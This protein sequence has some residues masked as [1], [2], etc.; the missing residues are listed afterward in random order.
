[1]S[2]I[3]CTYLSFGDVV[4]PIGAAAHHVDEGRFRIVSISRVCTFFSVVSTVTV[5]PAVLRDG[6]G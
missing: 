3:Y 1:M 4:A 5:G 6:R 2:Y